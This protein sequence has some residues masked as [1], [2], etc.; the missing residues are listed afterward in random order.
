MASISALQALK[1][2][3]KSNLKLVTPVDISKL[4][5]ILSENTRHKFIQRLEKYDILSRITKGKYLLSDNILNEYEIANLLVNPSY[6]SFE[7][8]LS[9]YG[10]LPQFPYT[11]SSATPRRSTKITYQEKEYEFTHISPEL[12][13]G[14]EKKDDF[15]IAS[16]EKALIDA[17]YLYS[18]GLRKIDLDELTLTI[19]D[20]AKFD[21][22][23]SLIKY[24]PFQK[25]LNRLKFN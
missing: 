22:F 19:I 24:R 12:F 16:P 3:K 5:G 23:A 14:F 25:K 13:W 20:K 4:F 11:L 8:A 6:I 10:I 9:F 1:T 7:S 18:K 15:L 17:I 21:Q 2:L